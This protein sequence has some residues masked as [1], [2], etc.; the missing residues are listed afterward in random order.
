VPELLLLL[1]ATGGAALAWFGARAHFA[2]VRVA[3]RAALESRVLAAEAVQ[4]ELRKQ[5]SGSELEL[6]EL[7]AAL[8]AER[9]RRA[10]AEARVGD[11]ERLADSF[12]AL[13]GEAL[14]AN[15]EAFLRL[16]REAVNTVVVEARGDLDRRQDAIATLVRPLED[17]LRRYEAE[18]REVERAREQAYGG[19]K[20]E[21][22][23]LS[24]ETGSLATALRTP[25]VRG[26]WGEI[27]LHRV[28][29]LAGLSAHCDFVEQASIASESGRRRPDLI[30]HLPA[31][32]QIVVDAKVPLTAYLEAMDAP[33]E[34]ERRAA[35][36]RHA[37]QVRSHMNQLAGKAYWAD[38]EC[39]PELV[40]MFI[41]GEPFFAAAV[42]AD[43]S[44]IEDGMAK[45]V[46]LATPTTLIAL[47]RAV[48]YGWRQEQ[49]AASAT[50]ISDL[51]K[52][53]YDR[54]LV[55][56]SHF[57]E[58]G[59]KLGKAVDAYN[60]VL[61]SMEARVLPAARRFKDLGA[62]PGPEIPPLEPVDHAP[63]QLNAAD[64]PRQLDAGEVGQGTG[65]QG[66]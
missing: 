39:T 45:G 50:T 28:V 49:V 13:S 56:A 29:E 66:A 38:V 51:G 17:T 6:S 60:R 31:R 8:D 2:R 64:V 14:H 3:E 25:Q 18:L 32:R 65:V 11:R 20:H 58:V 7:R 10:G 48:A 57:Q 21:L 30:V 35:L 61:A 43:R 19:L 47:L 24:R 33:T 34:P 44:L 4:D 52:Q 59:E 12:K 5:V 41:P 37:S 54:L 27:T 53:L 22:E 62:G 36:E 26:R 55:L 1:A 46:V 15:S 40:V 16:A 42:D 23:N 63:R 9:V